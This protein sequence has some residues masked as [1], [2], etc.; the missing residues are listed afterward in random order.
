VSDA[1]KAVGDKCHSVKLVYPFN[2]YGLFLPP[3]DNTGGVWLHS[4][5]PIS[6]YHVEA[7]VWGVYVVALCGVMWCGVAFNNYVLF[8]H[9][10][11]V[12]H[13]EDPIS[14]YHLEAKMW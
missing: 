6:F 5:D 7:K 2:N 12:L 1:I 8:L 4:E 14:L 11:K 9:L 3:S 13:S 10:C